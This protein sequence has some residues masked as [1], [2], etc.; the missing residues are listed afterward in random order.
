MWFYGKVWRSPHPT[1]MY[2]IPVMCYP[3]GWE[4]S[5]C[6]SIL[7]SVFEVRCTHQFQTCIN[8]GFGTFGVNKHDQTFLCIFFPTASFALMNI[9]HQKKV[10]D[11]SQMYCGCI[12][13]FVPWA[14]TFKGG[15]SVCRQD[16]PP[17]SLWCLMMGGWVDWSGIVWAGWKRGVLDRDLRLPSWGLSSRL[18]PSIHVSIVDL[19]FHFLRI[20]ASAV[21]FIPFSCCSTPSIILRRGSSLTKATSLEFR[22]H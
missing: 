14:A 17:T 20:N 13:G 18:H 8:F 4:T 2:F 21:V 12:I 7:F 10:V 5:Q 19:T 3:T 11:H 15:L 6:V 9:L 22:A 1:S 16:P